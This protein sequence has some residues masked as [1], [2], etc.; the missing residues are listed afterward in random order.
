MERKKILIVSRSFYPQNSPRSFRTTELTKELAKQ[1]HDVT[2]IIPKS[3]VHTA[4]EVEHGI[5]IKDLGEDAEAKPAPKGNGG[6]ISKAVNRFKEQFLLYPSIKLKDMVYNALK[7]EENKNYDMLISIAAPHPIHWGTAKG[8]KKYK[9]IA[10]TWVADCGDPFMLTHNLQ[11]KRAFYF[12]YYEKDFCRRADYITIPTIHAKDGYYTEFHNKLVVIPQG[13]NFEDIKLSERITSPDVIEFGYAGSLIKNR[14]DPSEL[15]TYL[16]KKN[17]DFKFIVYSKNKGF[18][19]SLVKQ[20]PGKV[21]YM[22]EADRVELLYHLSGLDFV[23]NFENVGTNQ[24]PS[25]LIDYAIIKKPV[26]SLMYGNLNTAAVDG[27]SK[28]DYTMQLQIENVDQYRIQNVAQN[29]VDL[30][31]K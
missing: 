6:F 21:V 5:T 15:L 27:F 24:S 30:A 19:D 26:L 25:K 7:K 20:F 29:F 16:T 23:L 18:V 1:G 13:F 17:I 31:T 11:Y 28:G 9:N 8:L 10:K 12:K 2:V 14:R 22:G 3:E 4:F